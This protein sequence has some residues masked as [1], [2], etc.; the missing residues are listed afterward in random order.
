MLAPKRDLSY[1]PHIDGLRAIAVVGVM[2]FHFGFENFPGGFVGVDL[3]FVISGFLITRIIINEFLYTGTFDFI[4]FYLR[5][6]RR[7]IPAL[8]FT[9]LIT[10]VFSII[11]LSPQ[12]LQQFGSSLIY[13]VFGVSN[14]FFWKESS[15]FDTTSIY[16]PLLHTWSLGVEEQFYIVWPFLIV[17]LLYKLP[18][19]TLLLFLLIGVL[20]FYLKSPIGDQ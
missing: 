7:I 8:Y 12:H 19:L 1:K 3:F 15:Y 17:F 4:S 5:R 13:A 18:K 6:A 9:L 11:I 20:S 10:F 16:K 2:L 14:I